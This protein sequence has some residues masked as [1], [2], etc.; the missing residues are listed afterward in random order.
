M[1]SRIRGQIRPGAAVEGT[2]GHL[3]RVIRVESETLEILTEP[4]D[5]Q[6]FI[7]HELI[8][9]VND[10]GSVE[11]CASR[12][13]LQRLSTAGAA[14]IPV[15]AQAVETL[16]LQ[17]EHLVPHTELEETGRVWIRKEVEELPRRLEVDAYVEEVTVEHVP[18]GRV[19]KEQEPA[20]EENG[21]YIMPIYEEQLVVVKRLVLKEEIRIHRQSTT[22]KRL[23]KDTVRHERLVIDDPDR[24]G[25]VREQY[26]TKRPEGAYAAGDIPPEDAEANEEP[27]LL[28][29]LGRKVLQ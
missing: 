20:R 16:E 10:D 12:A 19:V 13:E 8:R 17:E 1:E 5:H 29:K 21:V 15:A 24:T 4:T 14:G 2:D 7:P 22:E 25:R 28:E 26:A 11:L 6:L 18:I 9:R 27:G 23:F 3:G